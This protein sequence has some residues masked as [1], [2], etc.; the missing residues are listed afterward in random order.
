MPQRHPRAL[1]FDGL[2]NTRDLGGIRL[3][4]GGVIDCGKVIRSASPQFL[5]ETGAEEIYRYGVRTVI[6][7]RSPQEIAAEGLGPLMSYVRDGRVK[8]LAA[9]LLSDDARATDPIGTVDG[10]DD[11]AAHYINYLRA[12]ERF[13]AIAERVIETAAAGGATL[14]HCALGKDR[15]GV[16]V[17]V[18]LDAVGVD[19]HHIVD[20]YA[21]TA[22]HVPHM[23][24]RLAASQSYRRDFTSPNWAALAPQPHGIAGMLTW[25]ERTY[26]GAAQFLLDHGLS[27]SRLEQLRAE[28]QYFPVGDPRHRS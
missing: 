16:S 26:G 21:L 22:P 18:L 11:A 24:N 10:V 1:H 6:D 25:L 2:P 17:S 9:P 7:L 28:L 20:D 14:L 27:H 13:V 15:T 8:H 4:D 12:A 5:T 3:R 19:H 23:V